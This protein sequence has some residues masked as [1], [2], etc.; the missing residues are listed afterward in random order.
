MAEEKFDFEKSLLELEKI[1][2]KLESGQCSLEESIALFENG[3]KYTNECR[4]ALEKA[5]KKIISLT[6]AEQEA[7]NI[8]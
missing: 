4:N 6:E 7:E 5:E 3:V 1:I 8:D 2:A